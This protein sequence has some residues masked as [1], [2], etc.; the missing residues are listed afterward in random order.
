MS[1]SG[2]A[3]DSAVGGLAIMAGGVQQTRSLGPGLALGMGDAEVFDRLNA[4][5]IARDGELLDVRS[6]L[7]NT[8]A[9]VGATFAEARGTLMQIV[10]DF[11]LEAETMRNHG[12]YEAA[13]SLARLNQVVTEARA[14]LD[15]QDARVT[16]DLNDLAQRVAAQQQQMQQQQ[17]QQPIQQQLFVAAPTP[18]L[19]TSPGGTVR[20]LPGGPPAGVVLQP[21]PPAGFTTPP[22]QAPTNAT[23]AFDAWAAYRGSPPPDAW[24]AAAAAP[25]Q[26]QQQPGEQPRHSY[27]TP[28]GDGGRPREMR[29]DARGW[30][31]S[32]PKLDIGVYFDSFQIWKDRALMFLSRERPDVRKLLSWAETQTKETLQDGLVARAPRHLRPGR[33]RVRAP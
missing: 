16:Q 13:Q 6:G 26:P 9:A 22:R 27:M 20:F 17:Q 33:G 3:A 14:R 2:A 25:Q 10:H 5:G 19:V 18:Q 11:R 31:A 15:A 29:L 23:P 32:Q 1:A 28:G 30:G 24:A 8:Q 7:A 4:W 21:A 12:A